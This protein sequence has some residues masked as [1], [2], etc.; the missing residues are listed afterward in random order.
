MPVAELL[1]LHFLPCGWQVLLPIQ[2][3]R[4]PIS[5]RGINKSQNRRTVK[6]LILATTNGS[7]NPL[8]AQASC[9]KRSTL[10]LYARTWKSRPEPSASTGIRGVQRLTPVSTAMFTGLE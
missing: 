4:A 8:K 3:S 7:E 1:M 2:V 9:L 5:Q 6:N 10:Q